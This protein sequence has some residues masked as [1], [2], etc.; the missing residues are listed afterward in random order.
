MAKR[1]T[2]QIH[3]DKRVARAERAALA[4]P[5]SQSS[6][7]YNARVEVI[8]G[9]RKGF[10]GRVVACVVKGV[11]KPGGG[12]PCVVIEDKGCL[13]ECVAAVNVKTF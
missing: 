12:I 8:R 9:K 13:T 4:A 5:V 3:N 7:P 6:F 11:E 1:N 10:K 2:V